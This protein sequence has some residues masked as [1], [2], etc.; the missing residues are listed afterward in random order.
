MSSIADSVSV[1]ATPP[2]G[3]AAANNGPQL[4]AA[5]VGFT[6]ASMMLA[7][8]LIVLCG[9]VPLPAGVVAKAAPFALFTRF[10]TV[11]N[12]FTMPV[13]FVL[14]VPIAVLPGVMNCDSAYTV[15]TDVTSLMCTYVDEVNALQS[16]RA[17]IITA[18]LF[19][20]P[21]EL[22][23]VATTYTCVD[24][25]GQV[26]VPVTLKVPSVADVIAP[27]NKGVAPVPYPDVP[28]AY[29]VI[30]AP[31]IGCCPPCTTPDRITVVLG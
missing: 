17:A 28:A 11:M 1:G 20:T 9:A 10:A 31:E 8:V 30:C 26:Y 18:A 23:P 21:P 5:V 27:F 14:L 15:A 12:P 4:L 2:L 7:S 19:V 24:A 25:V 16:P 29:I 3:F 13:T 22:P 6:H